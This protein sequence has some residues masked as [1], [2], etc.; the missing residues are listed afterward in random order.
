MVAHADRDIVYSARYYAPPGS[1]R[2]SYFHLY[3]INPD[4]TG[5][6]QLT[7]GDRDDIAP[8][9]SP[10][11][12]RVLFLR[13]DGTVCLTDADGHRLRTLAT[14]VG[15]DFVTDLT[16]L[17]DGRTVSF[18]HYRDKVQTRTQA[19]WL[20]DEKTG[21]SRRFPG[22][23][24]G[25]ASPDGRWL[26]LNDD[27]GPRLISLSGKRLFRVGSDFTRPVWLNPQRLIGVIA[28]PSYYGPVGLQ[29]R[30]LSGRRQ[31]RLPLRYPKPGPWSVNPPDD[32]G[33]LLPS[34]RPGTVVYALNEHNST[35][36]ALAAFF[37]VPLSD[38][39]M[40]F[41]AEGQFLA[42][43]PDGSRFCTAPGRDTWTYKERKWDGTFRTV[44]AAP[45]QVGS[46]GGGR[47]KTITPDLVWVTGADWRK[48]Q[49]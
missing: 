39:A 17:P 21:Q 37:R 14:F 33:W 40:Q 36:G 32:D 41:L 11:G 26:F 25:E 46:S 23:T 5:R 28:G 24:D 29:E 4:G 42:W 35:V 18:V 12:R 31:R 47:L 7:Y 34:P 38:G 9:W 10:D 15:L 45:L 19:L 2:T 44:W 30:D 20:L 49:P 43:S 27:A 3:R 1:H 16:W 13:G 22:A 6:T 8:Q 48:R